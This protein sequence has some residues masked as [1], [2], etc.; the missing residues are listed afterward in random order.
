V[1]GAVLYWLGVVLMM[2]LLEPEFS[3]I[4]IPM[5]A[6]VLGAYGGWMTTSF[7]ALA[8]ALFAAGFGL[9]MTLPRTVLTGIAFL[10]FIIAATGV[11]VAGLFPM[12]S[13]GSPG[14]LSGRWHAVG[15]L[16]A[17]PAMAL[18][19]LLFSLSFR[20]DHYWRTI[21]VPSLTLSGSIVAL[22][23]FARF[24]RLPLGPPGYMQRVFFALLIPWML[25]VGF[26]L[27]R[28]G[29]DPS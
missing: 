11:L 27:I 29:R 4:K 19:P 10:L 20:R 5:S 16:F 25:L 1:I 12:N 14:A 23:F 6:Y 24:L 21:S 28:V 17:F 26:Q 22:Y 3:P 9:A 2:H 18:G 15:G 7:F 8:A 13:P